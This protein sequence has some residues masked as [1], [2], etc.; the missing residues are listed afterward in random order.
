MINL[1]I[2]LLLMGVSSLI[3]GIIVAIPYKKKLKKYYLDDIF[4]TIGEMRYCPNKDRL[5]RNADRLRGNIAQAA[6][7]GWNNLFIDIDKG[8]LEMIEERLLEDFAPVQIDSFATIRTQYCTDPQPEFIPKKN[9]KKK[10][11]PF[12]K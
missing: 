11:F 7:E 4:G 8:M 10:L 9:P 12:W 3:T 5:E 1:L 2:L 6:T